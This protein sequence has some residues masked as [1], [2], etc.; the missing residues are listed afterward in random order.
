MKK[1]P[2]IYFEKKP[3][4]NKKPQTYKTFKKVQTE[5]EMHATGTCT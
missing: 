2:R 3:E 4:N 5:L 1:N